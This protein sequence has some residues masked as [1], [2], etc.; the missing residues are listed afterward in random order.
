MQPEMYLAHASGIFDYHMSVDDTIRREQN[1]FV[2]TFKEMLRLHGDLEKVE[3]LF[4]SK[5]SPWLFLALAASTLMK[6]KEFFLVE[7]EVSSIE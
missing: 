5:D 4:C 1:L 6:E 3:S 7:L 2:N